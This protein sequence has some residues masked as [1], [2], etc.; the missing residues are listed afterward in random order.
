VSSVSL[1]LRLLITT[2]TQRTQRPEEVKLSPS[3]LC[4][5]CVSVVL[6]L[7]LRKFSSIV[8]R[9][10]SIHEKLAGEVIDQPA[11]SISETGEAY[12]R[13]DAAGRISQ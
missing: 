10:V 6:S 12:Q 1:W 11:K 9:W 5:L 4:A 2:E 7:L 3:G 8:A 13:V